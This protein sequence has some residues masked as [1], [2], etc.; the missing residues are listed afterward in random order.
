M[1]RALP[2]FMCRLKKA[3]RTGSRSS[4]PTETATEFTIKWFDY[5]WGMLGLGN[6]LNNSSVK[7]EVT[8]DFNYTRST[9][10]IGDGWSA[11]SA[12]G[13]PTIQYNE[14]A[15]DAS[16]GWMKVTFDEAQT[17]FW[18]LQN[19]TILD[20]RVEVGSTATISYKIFLDTA[21]LWGDN[22]ENDDDSIPW[23]SYYGSNGNSSTSVTAG[24]STHTSI[25]NSIS[26]TSTSNIIQ[27]RQ[28]FYNPRDLPLAG[29]EVYIKDL[30]ISITYT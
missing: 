11:F 7:R 16:E 8:E 23:Q 5:L 29:A 12:S 24:S 14:T 20:G 4:E 9:I 13:S 1:M 2:G 28:A 19:T 21:A 26:A 18:A 22:S 25:S 30:S 6:S 3:G 10:V 27:L 17:D 15:P